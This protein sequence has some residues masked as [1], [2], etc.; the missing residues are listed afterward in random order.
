MLV[1]LAVISHPRVGAGNRLNRNR[2]LLTVSRV[3]RRR[4]RWFEAADFL[5]TERGFV[6]QALCRRRVNLAALGANG[7]ASA[8][9]GEKLVLLWKIF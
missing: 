7:F 4:H 2:V 8:M 5:W 9:P 3:E 6:E 1:S